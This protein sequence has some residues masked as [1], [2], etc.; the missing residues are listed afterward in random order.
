MSWLDFEDFL[1]VVHLVASKEVAPCILPCT[2]K[3]NRMGSSR[4]KTGRRRVSDADVAHLLIGDF[5]H[6]N[7]DAH[8][9]EEVATA[10]DIAAIIHPTWKSGGVHGQRWRVISPLAAPIPAREYPRVWIAWA[11]QMERRLHRLGEVRPERGWLDW[12]GKAVTQPAILPCRPSGPSDTWGGTNPT[13]ILVEG[14]GV[15]VAELVRAG[16]SAKPSG[17]HRSRQSGSEDI[18][19]YEGKPDAEGAVRALEKM[20]VGKVPNL[21]NSMDAVALAKRDG[22]T[23]SRGR[24]HATLSGC[25]FAMFRVGE[26]S[27]NIAEMLD[28]VVDSTGPHKKLAH[29]ATRL[30][31]YFDKRA[32]DDDEPADGL[33][34]AVV[35]ALDVPREQRDALRRYCRVL[36]R[37][38]RLR[39]P[40]GG[41]IDHGG[42]ARVLGVNV[43]VATAWRGALER[44]GLVV[45]V[46]EKQG[47]R[48]RLLLEARAEIVEVIED[49]EIG[50]AAK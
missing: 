42:L 2:I 1:M 17:S 48:Y 10:N 6:G 20:G 39:S 34:G 47:R 23:T 37:H 27:D 22:I 15:E 33:V 29:D 21:I 36:C 5:D 14:R 40:G 24:R 11:R 49:I 18:Q 3:P 7:L 9:V 30:Y 32:R 46:G 13:P 28:E 25:C 41:A 8:L 44:A 50:R 31:A 35:G 45:S 12:S 19:P 43:R 16:G 38:R 26:P 4:T